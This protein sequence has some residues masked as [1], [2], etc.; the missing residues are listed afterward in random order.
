[1]EGSASAVEQQH[2]AH[3]LIAVGER[4]RRRAGGMKRAVIEGEVE[5]KNFI[6]LPPIT[7]E[8]NGGQ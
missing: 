6:L 1:M 5:A 7:A 4:L 3:R 8:F 2:Y